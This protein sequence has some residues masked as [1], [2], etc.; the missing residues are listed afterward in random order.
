MMQK[1][2]AEILTNNYNFEVTLLINQK[3]DEMKDAIY[4]IR[5]KMQSSDNL[6]IYYAGHGELDIE[7][8]RG[9]WLPIDADNEKRSKWI[10]NSYIIDN[11]KAT[12]AKHVLLISDSCFSGSLMRSKE[13]ISYSK[14]LS[15]V[16]SKKTRVVITSAGGDEPASDYGEN[17]HSVFAN[18]LIN[19]LLDN[20]KIVLSDDLFPEIRK[21]VINNADQVPEMSVLLKAGHDGGDF[22]FVPK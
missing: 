18:A 3:H 21:Y 10:N 15:K 7:E 6:I 16:V 9:Y 22:I 12:K 13:E 8:N 14:E 4:D 2:I 19:S 20:N 17:N 1:K 11:I 5:K